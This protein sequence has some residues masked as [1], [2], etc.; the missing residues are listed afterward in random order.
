M[1]CAGSDASRGAVR[2]CGDVLRRDGAGAKPTVALCSAHVPRPG[3]ARP[4]P[5]LRCAQRHSRLRSG[6]VASSSRLLISVP[7]LESAGWRCRTGKAG[8][9]RAFLH[10]DA[11]QRVGQ[12]AVERTARCVAEHSVEA[13][14]CWR[15]PVSSMKQSCPR[16]WA[17]FEKVDE[18]LGRALAA[19]LGPNEQALE[20]GVFG[21]KEHRRRWHRLRCCAPRR[22]L[23]RL[24]RVG[25]GRRRGGWAPGRAAFGRRRVRR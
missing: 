25:R 18:R 17:C 14:L 1:L 5:L 12:V 10:E 11:A 2:C 8:S 6:G 21:R 13:E 3:G 4:P 7:E 20:L 15:T 22:T 9:G 16:A 23:R 19:V 24:R